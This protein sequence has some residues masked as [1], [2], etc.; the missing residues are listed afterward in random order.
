MKHAWNACPKCKSQNLSAEP[1]EGEGDEI[2]RDVTCNKCEFEWQEIFIFSQNY[3]MDAKRLD[4]K[5]NAL[6]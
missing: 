5:G 1:F 4:C 2:Y 6:E 3:N